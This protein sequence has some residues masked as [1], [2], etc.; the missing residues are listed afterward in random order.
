M[1][2]RVPNRSV[3]IRSNTVLSIEPPAKHKFMMSRLLLSF[4]IS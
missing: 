3:V 1:S 2:Q 4:K